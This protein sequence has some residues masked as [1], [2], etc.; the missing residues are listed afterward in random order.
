MQEAVVRRYTPRQAAVLFVRRPEEVNEA[1]AEDIAHMVS[2]SAE[3]AAACALA[4]C[5]AQ[6]VRQRLPEALTPWLEAAQ[7]TILT[8]FRQFAASLAQDKAAVTAALQYPWSSGQA[9]GQINRL[10]LIKR[11]MYGRANFDL[12]RQRVLAA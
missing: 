7:S 1:E 11:T 4:Q 9:E 5:F 8:E 12:L 10:K 2:A 6:M 3:I